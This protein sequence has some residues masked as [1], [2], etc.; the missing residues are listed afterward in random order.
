MRVN[1][2]MCVGDGGGRVKMGWREISRRSRRMVEPD[3][4]VDLR[5]FGC[6]H[7]MA[8]K[9]PTFA[10]RKTHKM[11]S[12]PDAHI[13]LAELVDLCLDVFREA[14]SDVQTHPAKRKRVVKKA[15]KKALMTSY[16]PP[17]GITD[18]RRKNTINKRM[19]TKARK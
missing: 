13:I 18:C 4:A 2:W 1:K 12:V 7:Q 19:E 17:T 6:T 9:P 8:E 10:T 11:R 3:E 14:G 5:L 15:K 16:G